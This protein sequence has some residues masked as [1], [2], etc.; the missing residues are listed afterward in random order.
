MLIDWFTV[1]AQVVNFLILLVLLKIFLF[2]RIKHAMDQ[3]ENN[4][5]ERFDKAE[6]QEAAAEDVRK[7][8][9]K[10]TQSLEDD[11]DA[12]LKEAD[13]EAKERR[14]SL[15]Q[16]AQEEVEGLKKKWQH[17]L[18]QEK[19]SFFDRFKKQAARLI[20]DTVEKTLSHLADV[21]AQD[22]AVKKFLS[23]FEELDKEELPRK[24]ETQPQV[25]TGFELSESQQKSIQKAVSQKLPD[26]GNI[27]F[28]VR[29]ELVFGIAFAA[30]GKKMTWHAHDYVSALEKHIDQA[31]ESKDHEPEKQ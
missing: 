2:D 16:E 11:R 9:E 31:I 13:K 6:E 22:Q 14:E 29:P 7:T 20:F 25:S 15:I 17:A 27:A 10:K 18:E 3:R 19:A 28:E 8:F 12:R 23:R 24:G 30:G 21:R 26:L 5:K 1:G 4:I